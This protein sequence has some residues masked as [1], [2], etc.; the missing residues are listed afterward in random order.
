MKRLTRSALWMSAA[1]LCA[2]TAGDAIAQSKPA[3]P[4]G[5]RPASGP[6]AL[7]SRPRLSEMC[8]ADLR[9]FC[10]SVAPGQGRQT[11]CLKR[12]NNQLRRS[13]RL[14][15]RRPLTQDMAPRPR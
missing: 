1:L 15:L 8:A 11:R 3:A 5:G 6:S 4:G 2:A 9:R 12:R 7:S 10:P 13:C 14:F